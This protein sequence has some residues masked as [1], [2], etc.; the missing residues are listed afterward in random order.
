MNPI[1]AGQV[2]HVLTF[3]GGGLAALGYV[4]PAGWEILAGLLVWLIGAAWS[5]VEKRRAPP[6][7]DTP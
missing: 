4:D 7:G 1:V 2:R 6:P 5:L 3:V